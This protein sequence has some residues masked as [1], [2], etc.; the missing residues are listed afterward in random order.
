M[1]YRGVMCRGDRAM[2]PRKGDIV[3]PHGLLGRTPGRWRRA[4]PGRVLP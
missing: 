2:G 4:P 3:G 1:A